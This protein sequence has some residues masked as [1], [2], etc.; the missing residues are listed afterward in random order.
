VF[1]GW[2]G[3]IEKLGKAE[4]QKTEKKRSFFQIG[5]AP[6]SLSKPREVVARFAS[7]R[8]VRFIVTTYPSGNS[9]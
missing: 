5:Y 7:D 1:N 3:L 8:Y 9:P 6:A 2:D 4:L